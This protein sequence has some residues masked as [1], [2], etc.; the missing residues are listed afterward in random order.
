M[1]RTNFTGVMGA[2]GAGTTPGSSDS[3][4]QTGTQNMTTLQDSTESITVRGSTGV[5][6]TTTDTKAALSL[7]AGLQLAISLVLSVAVG[8][9]AQGEQLAQQLTQ[10]V[11]TTQRNTQSILVENSSAV[12][13]T[14]VDTDI[15]ANIQALL[16]LLVSIVARLNI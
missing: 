8:S 14:T 3:F 13:V 12:N 6:V 7:Q 2:A 11:T 1:S 16:Q 15:A 5:N 10:Q 4:R 9:T